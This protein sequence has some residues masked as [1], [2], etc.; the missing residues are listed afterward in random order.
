[1][2]FKR[3]STVP[4]APPKPSVVGTTSGSAGEP[5]KGQTVLALSYFL[6]SRFQLTKLAVIRMSAWGHGEENESG[7]RKKKK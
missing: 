5:I 7:N 2:T 3:Y 1:M 6:G 4:P